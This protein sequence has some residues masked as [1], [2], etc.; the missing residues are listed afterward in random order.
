MISFSAIFKH[1]WPHIKKYKFSFYLLFF[2]QTVRVFTSVIIPPIILRKILDLLSNSPDSTGTAESLFYYVFLFSLVIVF[3]YLMNRIT[4][5]AT[6]YF[7]SNVI[8]DL[9]NYVFEKLTKHSYNFFT[10]QFAGGLVSKAKRFV[11]GFE[12]MHDLFL[13][14]FYVT[15]LSVVG[16][17]YVMFLEVPKI[18]FVFIIWAILYFIFT[19]FFIRYKMKY[20]LLEAE[21]DSRVGGSLADVISNIVTMKIF[22]SRDSEIN[23]YK[24]VTESEKQHRTK[25]WHW[26]NIQDASQGFLM[27]FINISILYMLAH[28]WVD[29]LITAGVFV[30]IQ[31]YM[32]NLFDKLWGIVKAMTKFIKAMTEMK[33]VSDIFDKTPEILDPEIP[34]NLKIKDGFI[35][36]KNVCFEYIEDRKVF[37]GF[38]LNIKSGE[39]IGLVGHSGSGKSTIT[40][41]LL[42]FSDVDSGSV[43][44][45]GQNIANITQDDLRSAISYVPQEPILFH[46]TIKENIAYS[47]QHAKFEDIIKAAQKAH[48]HDFISNLQYGYDTLVGERGVKL[49]GGERQRIAIARAMLKQAPILILDEATSSLDSISEKYIQDAFNLLMEGKTT[50]VIAH[51]LSTIQK[52]DRIIV[53]EDGKIVEEGAHNDLIEKNGKYAEL[54]NHQ[55]GGFIE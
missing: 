4:G 11:R 44:I 14:E 10:N 43:C 15:L 40:K 16:I 6:V 13:F 18:A 51:R 9:H 2:T 38:N 22:S 1:I 41:L 8:R 7:Q 26:G 27:I 39:R 29:G 35:E 42:R 50:I 30:L 20:D 46:R 33:E 5:Y 31:S 17:F 49:S 25:A 19:S 3:G 32:V 23:K 54:W 45:D 53:L 21:A 37:S 28:S 52:M 48:A 47:N 34:E 12:T 24:E 36:F 55:V